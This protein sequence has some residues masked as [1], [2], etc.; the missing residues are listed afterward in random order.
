[1]KRSARI[2]VAIVSL[3][4]LFAVFSKDPFGMNGRIKT[5]TGSGA[6]DYSTATSVAGSATPVDTLTLVEFYAG[7]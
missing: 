7:F 6:A 4:F 5:A 3:A 1:M 2:I